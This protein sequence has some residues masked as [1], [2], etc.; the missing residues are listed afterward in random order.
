MKT[1]LLLQET[2]N[3]I[4]FEARSELNMQELRVES[5]EGA[6]QELVI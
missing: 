6:L 5:A 3:H 2:K 4:L 1:R